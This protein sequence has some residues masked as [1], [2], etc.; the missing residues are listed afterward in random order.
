[1]GRAG[2]R[3]EPPVVPTHLNYPV[4]RLTDVGAM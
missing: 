4:A 1:M 2:D 3:P